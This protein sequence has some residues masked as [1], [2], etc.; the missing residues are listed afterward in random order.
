[1]PPKQRITREMILERSFEMFCRDGM[2]AVN[3]R[4]VAKALN[5]STQPIFSY[6]AG[7]DDLKNALENKAKETFEA[8]ITNLP[9][10]G[11]PV[12]N[13]CTAYVSFAAVQP[14]LFK[15]LFMRS[16]EGPAYVFMTKEQLEQLAQSEAAYTGL[17]AQKAEKALIHM[18]VYTHGYASMLAGGQMKST[19]E[20][21]AEYICAA[22]RYLLV[23]LDR[24][25]D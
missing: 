11:D 3:A 8:A 21:I 9:Q 15:Y 14:C 12:V 22:H 2:D 16:K 24:D 5:C 23:A 25:E 4:S 1:M 10:D 20:H 17:S 7:M 6:Y 13:I 18:C 19:L